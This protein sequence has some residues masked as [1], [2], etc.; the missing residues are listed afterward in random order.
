MRMH[1][2]EISEIRE[3]KGER[4]LPVSDDFHF[5]KELK[6]KPMFAKELHAHGFDNEPTTNGFEFP[7]ELKPRF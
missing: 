7:K 2:H 3:D 1:F 4:S 6:V 5:P